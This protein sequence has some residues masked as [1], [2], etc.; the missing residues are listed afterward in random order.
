MACRM[1]P[2][3]RIPNARCGHCRRSWDSEV[4]CHCPA[5]LTLVL[6]LHSGISSN[7]RLFTQRYP[8][9]HETPPDSGRITS[10]HF[11]NLI[12]AHAAQI[13]RA[14]PSMP[15][16]TSS[17]VSHPMLGLRERSQVLWSIIG[18]Q[19]IDVVNMLFTD[20]PAV[21]DAMLVGFDVL[22]HSDM[23]CEPYIPMTAETPSRLMIGNVFTRPQK[24][25]L[26]NQTALPAAIRTAPLL[27]RAFHF[28]AAANAN[29]DG[30]A[31]NLYVSLLCHTTF[32][33]LR[34]F[35]Q[36]DCPVR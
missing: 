16:R 1:T 2:R 27:P 26:T 13:H 14:D 10:D 31:A 9:L 21:P 33:S 36:H 18:L 23:P 17:R 4:E 5:V 19:P 34:E 12:R 30:H 32:A 20:D 7:A 3:R 35:D 8:Q 15:F 25:R 22:T 24:T 6:R 29:N 11:G 28:P